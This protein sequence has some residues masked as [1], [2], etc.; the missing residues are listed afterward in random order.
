MEPPGIRTLQ[1]LN[2]LVGA[3]L[4]L[5]F[6]LA[7]E[8]WSRMGWSLSQI[9]WAMAGSNLCYAA[10]VGL[11]GRLSDGWG[12]ARTALLGA[13]ICMLAALIALGSGSAFG[14]LIGT[15]LG[16]AGSAIFF[17]GNVGLFSD[18]RDV[19][20]ERAQPLHLKVSHYNLGW[21]GGNVVGF[22]LAWCF[23]LLPAQVGWAT[24][25]LFMSVILFTL[26]RWRSLPARPPLADGD[27]A[28]HPALP[29]LTWIGR[30]SLLIYCMMGMAFISLLEPALKQQG[31]SGLAAHHGYTVACFG[32]A[33]G[34]FV[35]FI[36]LGRWGG[37]VLQPWRL[38]AAQIPIMVAALGVVSLAHSEAPSELILFMLALLLGVGFAAVYTGSIY[39][40]LR[41]PHGAAQAAAR[42]ETALGIGS[43]IGPALCGLFMS[44][45]GGGALDSLGLWM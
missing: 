14:A 37:W 41:L 35:M 39:Y 11:G 6:P 44:H 13:G 24:I 40:S 10:I 5:S 42:H 31:Q 3:G 12:R 7:I 26:W 1:L 20:G 28:P 19:S 38:L 16:C 30:G 15:M 29:Q 33:V 36:V 18:A 32:Y 34:Y 27:R 22:G 17:P 9:G 25:V 45:V 23:V 8:T 4:Y 43:T 2:A 21:S